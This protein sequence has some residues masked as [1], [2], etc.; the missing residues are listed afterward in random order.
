MWFGVTLNLAFLQ[1]KVDLGYNTSKGS[2]IPMAVSIALRCEGHD[3]RTSSIDMALGDCAKSSTILS[4]WET[5][6]EAT[7]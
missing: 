7:F 1:P 2:K 3:W 6:P 5:L 4:D